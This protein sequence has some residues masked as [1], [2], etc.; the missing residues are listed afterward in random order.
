MPFISFYHISFG[1][2]DRWVHELHDVREERLLH[3]STCRKNQT[4]KFPTI[5]VLSDIDI[6]YH[7]FHFMS[8]VPSRHQVRP[9]QLCCWCVPGS[10]PTSALCC[11]RQIAT[12]LWTTWWTV[13]PRP[14]CMWSEWGDPRPRGW[15]WSN[16]TCWKWWSSTAIAPAPTRMIHNAQSVPYCPGKD[17]KR[18]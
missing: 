8:Q 10:F 7:D 17:D 2:L 3:P 15:T 6:W 4:L 1:I 12:S 11:A 9:P 13:A 16:T 5:P 14:S 18:W